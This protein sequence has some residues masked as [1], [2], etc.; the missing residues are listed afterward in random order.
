MRVFRGFPQSSGYRRYKMKQHCYV[1]E[2][3]KLY[4]HLEQ[5]KDQALLI[6]P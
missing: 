4:T 3:S 6:I 1:K 2:E 5:G